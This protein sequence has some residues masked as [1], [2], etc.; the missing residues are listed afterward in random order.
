MQGVFHPVKTHKQIIAVDD[1]V[2]NQQNMMKWCHEVSKG[3]TDVHDKQ[4]S[5]RLSLISDNIIQKIE[6]EI[7][8]SWC[9]MIRELHHIIPEVSKTT[10][11]EVVKEKLRQRKLYTLE[12]QNV[13]R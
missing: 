11:H 12:A 13:N 10:I 1:D 9:E 5:G 7:H 6:G 2:M 4:R 3:R 8:A